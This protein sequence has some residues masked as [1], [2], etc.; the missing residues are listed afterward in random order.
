M[1]HQSILNAPSDRIDA[2]VGSTL[3]CK[4]MKILTM[5]YGP[6]WKTARKLFHG[7]L[8]INVAKTYIPYQSLESK[9]MLHEI[10]KAR[11][12]SSTAS[13]GTVAV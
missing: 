5:R 6:R 13:S 2:Y 1:S 11:P 3:A 8:H 10:R 7:I 12:T 4:D 9:Q